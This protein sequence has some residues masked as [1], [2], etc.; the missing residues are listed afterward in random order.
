MKQLTYAITVLASIVVVGIGIHSMDTLSMTAIGF[1][2]WA[3]SPYLFA[4]FMIERSRKSMAVKILFGV[5]LFIVVAGIYLLV[6]AMYLHP[7]AQGALAF[8]VVPMYQWMILLITAL[9]LYLI[10]KKQGDR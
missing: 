1:L 9:P 2:I 7:D 10:N 6:D 3:I 5:S 4:L 8:V